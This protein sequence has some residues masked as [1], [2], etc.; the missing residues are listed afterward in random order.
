MAEKSTSNQKEPSLLIRLIPMLQW[1]PQYESGWLRFD[2]IAGLTVAALV[3]P[4]CITY[5]LAVKFSV[6]HR[7][8]LKSHLQTA[9]RSFLHPLPLKIA[10][11]PAP[12]QEVA[13]VPALQDQHRPNQCIDYKDDATPQD[14]SQRGKR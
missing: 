6:L 14:E 8:P 5:P 2:L 11:Q 9:L 3:N 12:D 7:A 10:F 4:S 13:E 1:F